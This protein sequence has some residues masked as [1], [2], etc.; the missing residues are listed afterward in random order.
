MD[1]FALVLAT[2]DWHPAN[3][4]SF[5]ANHPNRQP[6]EVIDLNG[7][8]QILWPVHCVQGHPARLSPPKFARNVF[9]KFSKRELTLGSTATAVFLTTAEDALPVWPNTCGSGTSTNFLSAAW[10]QITVSSFLL[11]IVSIPASA[12][13]YRGRMPGRRFEA[14]RL[15]RS[16]R[17]NAQ[18]GRVD[19][20]FHQLGL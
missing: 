8:M 20:R 19:R 2:Q 4:G 9:T 17:G 18:V 6:G 1:R 16:D 10:R 13:A 11:L 3:H 5:A 12:P 14:G 15:R 7:I